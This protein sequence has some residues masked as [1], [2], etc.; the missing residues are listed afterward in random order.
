MLCLVWFFDYSWTQ[1]IIIAIVEPLAWVAVFALAVQTAE[2]VLAPTT[3]DPRTEFVADLAALLAATAVTLHNTDSDAGADDQELDGDRSSPS[4]TQII[5]MD[6]VGGDASVSPAASSEQPPDPDISDL[7]TEDST[8]WIPI[9]SGTPRFFPFGTPEDPLPDSVRLWP[10]L[11]EWREDGDE[12]RALASRIEQS[13]DHIELGLPRLAGRRE[14]VVRSSVRHIAARVAATLRD[15]ATGVILGGTE[16]DRQLPE[17]L[18]RALVAASWGRWDELA[19]EEAQPAVER[20]LNRFG[21]R[22]AIAAL[23]IAIGILIPIWF[24]ELLAD[25]TA[26]FRIALFSAAV[27]GITEAPK[28]A[29]EKLTTFAQSA[30]NRPR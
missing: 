3:I 30:V 19:A 9:D 26:Q 28:A 17:K 21:W 10:G 4:A 8:D 15:H 20:F 6:S 7:P 1:V 12:R 13:A 11:W 18:S 29:V 27:L 2:I 16:L 25:S 23:L 14:T 5:P 22:I 24:H